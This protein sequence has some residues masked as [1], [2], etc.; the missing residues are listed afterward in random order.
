MSHKS[1]AHIS[2]DMLIHICN[3]CIKEHEEFTG[4][5]VPIYKRREF[6]IL[7][8]KFVEHDVMDYPRWAYRNCGLITRL[9][10]LRGIALAVLNDDSLVDKDIRLT[11]TTYSELL[12]M[13]NKSEKFEPFVFAGGY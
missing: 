13:Y 12:K 11:E 4:D 10:N 6:S 5:K 9:K 3:F 2:P 8:L 1:F 7:K